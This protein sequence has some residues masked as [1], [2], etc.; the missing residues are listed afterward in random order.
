MSDFVLPDIIAKLLVDAGDGDLFSASGADKWPIYTGF[1][2]D[3]KDQAICIYG[4]A[5]SPDGRIMRTGERIEHPGIQIRIRSLKY[6]PTS[7]KA[8]QIAA[9]IDSIAGDEVT[10]EPGTVY[11]IANI[12]RSGTP[13]NLGPEEATGSKRRFN[14]TVNATVTYRKNT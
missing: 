3:D 5:G 1:L 2:P 11:S 7:L 10:M 6:V 12:S 9:T 14:F 8:D 4:T 13:L